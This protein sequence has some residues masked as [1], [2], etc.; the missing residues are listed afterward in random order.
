MIQEAEAAEPKTE[1]EVHT[2]SGCA[3]HPYPLRF[4]SKISSISFGSCTVTG[5][6]LPGN[7]GLLCSA[8][9]NTC[10]ELLTYN[11]NRKH[12]AELDAGKSMDCCCAMNLASRFLCSGVEGTKAPAAGSFC[13]ASTP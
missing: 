12:A 4:R 10:R 3:V 1:C 13:A 2:G 9:A 8:T 11:C 7:K 6:K 5:C